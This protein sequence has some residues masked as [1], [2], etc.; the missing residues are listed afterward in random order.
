MTKIIITAKMPAK[1]SAQ[2]MITA[3]RHAKVTIG[4]EK[5]DYNLANERYS[6]DPIKVPA[7]SSTDLTQCKAEQA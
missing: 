4:K 6:A 2:V 3:L 7:M 1:D 5:T